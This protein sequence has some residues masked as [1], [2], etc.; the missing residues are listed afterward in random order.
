LPGNI[1]GTEEREE[2]VEGSQTVSD[3]YKTSS[4]GHEIEV[5]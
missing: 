4:I 5:G 1:Q 3:R 2:R